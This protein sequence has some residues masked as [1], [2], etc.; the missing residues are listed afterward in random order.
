MAVE[1][2]GGLRKRGSEEL[3]AHRVNLMFGFMRILL[4]ESKLRI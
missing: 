4:F 1:K 3:D 2:T